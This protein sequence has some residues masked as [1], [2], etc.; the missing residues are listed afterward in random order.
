MNH[1]RSLFL[2]SCDDVAVALKDPRLSMLWEEPS[3]LEEQTVGSVA[4]HVAHSCRV[5]MMFL[6]QPVP[7]GQADFESAIDY[8]VKLLAVATEE[9]HEGIRHRGAEDAAVGPAGTYEQFVEELAALS[10]RLQVEPDDRLIDVYGGNTMRLDDYLATR[11]IEHVVHLDDLSRSIDGEAFRVS[12]AAERFVV[13]CG[14]EIGRRR[15]GGTSVVRALFRGP[16]DDGSTPF[17]VL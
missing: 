15:F 16:D 8:Y 7:D 13:E 2:E 1:S 5:A 17:P 4:A 6:D 9:M 10:G 14:V 12:S 11:I 3:V